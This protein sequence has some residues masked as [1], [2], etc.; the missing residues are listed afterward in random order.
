[1]IKDKLALKQ[2]IEADSKN[3]SLLFWRK[4]GIKRALRSRICSPINDQISV[5][6]Y[7][8][9]LRYTEY[10]MN[11]NGIG[12]KLISLYYMLKLRRLSKITGFQIPIRTVGKGL[13]IWHWGTIIINESSTIGENCVM[14]PG[15]V[16][17]HKNEGG[18]CP[19]IGNNVEINSGVRI[20]GDISIGDD[21]IIAPNAVVTHDIPSHSI[22]AGVPAKII[23]VR[24][25]EKS[26]WGKVNNL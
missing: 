14:R 21:V 5:W 17:G 26:Q 10:W 16:I 13:T 2:Y 24:K 6:A 18:G 3:Y 1:M 9:T 25:N 19:T 22:V 20:I 7:I 15:I 11:K 12:A 8:K 4:V 23:K